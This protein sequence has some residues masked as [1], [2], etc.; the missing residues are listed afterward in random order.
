MTEN[1]ALYRTDVTWERPVEGKKVALVHV[2]VVDIEKVEGGSHCA[3]VKG[4]EGTIAAA[5]ATRNEAIRA[6]H[7]LILDRA[8][9]AIEKGLSFQSVMDDVPCGIYIITVVEAQPEPEVALPMFGPWAK[10]DGLPPMH[11]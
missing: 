2:K 11:V 7:E 3:T 10:T 8:D 5:G 9:Y 6:A 4:A 1:D